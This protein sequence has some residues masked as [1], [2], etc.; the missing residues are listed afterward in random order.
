MLSESLLIQASDLR[1]LRHEL[2]AAGLFE[3]RQGPT[4]LK[5]VFFLTVAFGLLAL[6][7]VMPLWGTVLV[8]PVTAF[9]FCAA[10]MIGHEGGHRSFSSSPL[11]N[12]LMYHFLFP[13]LG[14][15]SALQWKDKHNVRHHGNP[16]VVGIDDDM[17]IWPLAYTRAEHLK[18]GPTRRFVQR[19]A[20]RFLWWPLTLLFT[21][22]MKIDSVSFAVKHVRKHGVTRAW[23]LD[24]FAQ[25]MHYVVWLV[26][27][28]LAF[29]FGPV[30]SFYVAL[31]ALVSLMLALV[32][33]PGHMG[34][35]IR[36]D[37]AC[38]YTLQF[39][40]TRNLIMPRWL[41]FFFIGLDHQIEHHMFPKIPHANLPRAAAIVRPWAERLGLPYHRIPYL[42]A[43][44]A[45][46]RYAASAWNYEP[47]PAGAG[48]LPA[49]PVAP[50]PEVPV[51]TAS[52]VVPSVSA[53]AGPSLVLPGY[54]LKTT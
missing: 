41:S 48:S 17:E 40:T 14:G 37:H 34:L 49:M 24:V 53:S 46:Q 11:G 30:F 13:F 19:H 42:S 52:V 6:H 54:G 36:H 25:V 21:W 27:P 5:L 33:T 3:R 29:G 26:L 45:V 7:T 39:E 51:V 28:S 4:T 38:G 47:V 15:L 44:A 35:P 10:A 50:A 1:A 22:S 31:F 18:A 2:T 16:N 43:V 23:V 32:F 20:Q 8:L 12:E 9:F